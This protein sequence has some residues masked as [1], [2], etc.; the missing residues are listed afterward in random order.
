M[1]YIHIIEKMRGFSCI[2][3]VHVFE[4]RR[5]FLKTWCLPEEESCIFGKGN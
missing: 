5:P 1:K 2:I 3:F 4:H